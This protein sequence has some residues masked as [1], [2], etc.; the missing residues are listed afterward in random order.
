MIK[1][2]LN[3]A[4]LTAILAFGSFA[5]YQYSYMQNVIAKQKVQIKNLIV[6]L[7]IQRNKK[8]IECFKEAIGTKKKKLLKELNNEKK[9]TFDDNATTI[10]F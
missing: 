2:Y 3:I 4:L 5:Y 6:K 8:D 7:Q 1:K 9:Q 10:Y